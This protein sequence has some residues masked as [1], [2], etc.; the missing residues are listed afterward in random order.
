MVTVHHYEVWDINRSDWVTQP[1]KG[2]AE[3]VREVKG[4]II[5]GT[6]EEVDVSAVDSYGLYHPPGHGR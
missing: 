1:F 4:R 3:R 2:T 6:A 5:P